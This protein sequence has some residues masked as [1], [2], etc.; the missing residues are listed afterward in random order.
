M[1]GI[2]LAGWL[3]FCLLVFTGGC[4]IRAFKYATAPVH[5]R[6]DLYPVAHEPG[7]DHGGSYLE[8]K[9]WWTKKRKKEHFAEIF[10]MVEEILL[11]KGVWENNRRLWWASLPFHWGLYLLVL[12]SAGLMAAMVGLRSPF[13]T[14]VLSVTGI[15]GGA[16]T[17]LGALALLYMR[18]TDQKL[19]PYTTP[20][21]RA[22]LVVLVL[23]GGLTVA[24][25]ASGP[26]MEAVQGGLTSVFGF[27]EVTVPFVWA[28]QM[29]LGALFLLYLPLTSMVHFFAKYFTYH[30][31]RWDDQPL[32][33]NPRMASRVQAA[34]GYGVDWSAAHIR[35]GN[36]WAE[37]ATKLPDSKE[38]EK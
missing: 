24:V 6:W 3:W 12:T 9:D 33:E 16:C 27:G 11:L 35:T 14:A 2:L 36:T 17:A 8:E 19:R 30:Q 20:L 32:D 10:A 22:N 7:R 28:L 13:F 15:L 18:T 21:D 31:V 25:V 38:G 5:L 34:L 29:V 23:F 4:L 1:M 37:V 26:G